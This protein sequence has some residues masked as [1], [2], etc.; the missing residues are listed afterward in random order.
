MDLQ[1]QFRVT[2]SA[3]I[4]GAPNILGLALIYQSLRLRATVRY[5]LSFT[6]IA[7]IRKI[8][9]ISR[10]VNKNEKA[11]LADLASSVTL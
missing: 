4:N 7:N 5:S 10:E 6:P 3:E 1:A 11:R 9:A 2:I 8:S